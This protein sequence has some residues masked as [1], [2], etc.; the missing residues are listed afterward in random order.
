MLGVLAPILT[1]K[2]EYYTVILNIE[3]DIKGVIL[4]LILQSSFLDWLHVLTAH[5][6]IQAFQ[7]LYEGTVIVNAVR[8]L[9]LTQSKEPGLGP[10]VRP[11][12][13][14][15]IVYLYRAG[16]PAACWFSCGGVYV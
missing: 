15:K 1:A 14:N 11:A 10:I 7:P 3:K 2:W 12:P 13:S 8:L 6:R 9:Y 16:E 5:V 4:T